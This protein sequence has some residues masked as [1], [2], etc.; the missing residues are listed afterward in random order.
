MKFIY[1]EELKR[2]IIKNLNLFYIFLGED[3]IF[4]KKNEKII[5]DFAKKQDFKENNIINVEKI[6]DW[7]KIISFYSSNN[8]FF[9]KKVLIINLIIKNL[10]SL[11]IKNINKLF[12]VKNLDILT[13]L[14]FNHL[15]ND[16]KNYLLKQKNIFN[17]NIVWCFTP[18]GSNFKKW[19][20]YELKEKKI[21]ITEN[22][23]LLLYKF[24]EGNTLFI[25][26][27]LNIMILTWKN[28][29]ITSKKLKNIINKFAIFTPSDW[30]NSIFENKIK[31][32]FYILDTFRKQKYNPL[33][34]VRSLQKDL[35]TLVN[36]KR[37]KK[38]NMNLFFKQNNIFFNRIK[39]FN[40]AIE[41]INFN[42]FLKVIRIL[43]QTDIKIKVE[44]N[45]NVWTELKTLTLLLS[46]KIK[47]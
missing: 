35:L 26:N 44:Y 36:M 8:L 16:F 38:T 20:L 21:E 43:L 47:N 13:I 41:S 27:I 39:F 22:A 34:L 19:L 45:H 42:N 2:K 1:S 14:K 23:F 5:L 25:Y 24:Y 15:S 10:N 46:S 17:A 18:Y 28:E 7:N 12:F 11:L 37:E 3:L 9:K 32:A 29:K 30:I 4:L 6:T 33:I 40:F 31:H